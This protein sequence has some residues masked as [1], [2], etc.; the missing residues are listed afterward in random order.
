[1]AHSPVLS[2]PVF[3]VPEVATRLQV[4][5]ARVRAMIAAGLLEAVK[6]GKRWVVSAASVEERGRVSVRAGRPLSPRRAWGLLLLASGARPAWLSPP[7]VSRLR[8]WLKAGRLPAL[9]PRLRTRAG[10]HRLRAHP[11]ELERLARSVVPAGVSAAADHDVDLAPSSGLLD[12]YVRSR[13]LARLLKRHRLEPSSRPNVILRAVEGPWPFRR[14]GGSAPAAVVAVDLIESADARERRAG[15]GL[16]G[17]L[18][19]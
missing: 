17:R 1:M 3:S 8:A 19:P 4:N 15:E 6:V 13:D 18:A 12:G 2:D 11:S 5:A 10:V 14:G 16:L 7:E 9:V